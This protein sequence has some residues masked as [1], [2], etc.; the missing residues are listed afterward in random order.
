M[1]ELRPYATG[2]YKGLIYCDTL[3]D[4]ENILEQLTKI[5]KK[6]F[7]KDYNCKIK[8]GCTEFSIKYPN[9]DTLENDGLEYNNVWEKYE[10]IIDENN[11]DLS[12]EKVSNPIIKG[13][14]L[15]DGLIIRNWLCFAKL[16]GDKS[17]EIITD[18]TYKSKFLDE[19]FLKKIKFCQ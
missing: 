15:S 5:C 16:I 3:K 2:K 4:S 14:S 6:H 13:M 17:Y 8:K 7:N 10:N 19:M 11:P 9:Y 1:I 12:F 18:K